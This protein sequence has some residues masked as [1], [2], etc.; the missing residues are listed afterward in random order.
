MTDTGGIGKDGKIPWKMPSDQRRFKAVTMGHTMIMGHAT[1]KSLGR[2]LPGRRHI[3]LS[4][5]GNVDTS[6][7][8][9]GNAASSLLQV[10]TSM[11]E[12]WAAVADHHRVFVIGGAQVYSAAEPECTR[13]YVSRIHDN[14]AIETDTSWALDGKWVLSAE[15]EMSAGP[16]DDFS[17]GWA[18]YLRD[19]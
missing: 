1:F 3:V 2:L 6:H 18:H 11:E 13:A 15:A 14:G 8:G 17:W 5:S 16:G 12:A 7:M 19:K 9:I 4:R 10:V